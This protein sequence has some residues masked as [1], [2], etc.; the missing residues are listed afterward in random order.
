M[1]VVNIEKE[2]IFVNLLRIYST[3]EALANRVLGL[4]THYTSPQKIALFF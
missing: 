1:G 2:S 4:A 3:E